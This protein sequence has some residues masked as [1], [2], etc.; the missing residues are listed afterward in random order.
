MRETVRSLRLYLI[1]SGA[2]ATFS[3]A[4]AIVGVGPSIEALW[5]L[6]SL[7]LSIAYLLLGVRLPTWLVSAPQ[8]IFRVLQIGMGYLVF[9]LALGAL[10]GAF[11]QIVVPMGLGLLITWYVL[12]NARR[13]AG[14]MHSAQSF[15]LQAPS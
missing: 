3:Y 13:L 7:A 10:S 6:P 2:L 11:A 15:P 1:L 8:R 14:E 12:R 4:R 5:A 9:V